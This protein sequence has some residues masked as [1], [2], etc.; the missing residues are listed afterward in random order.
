MVG[1]GRI[2]EAVAH[3]LRAFGISRILYSGRSTKAEAAARLGGAIHVPFY[4]LLAE[5]DF[6][7]VSC[8]LTAETRGMFNYEA[9]KRMKRNA[10][11]FRKSR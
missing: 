9:F 1:L 5:S 8:A 11:S 2:G 6:V 4:D 7:V 3:R 10:V